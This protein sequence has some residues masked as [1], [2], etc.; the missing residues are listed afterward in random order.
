MADER[1][2]KFEPIC[3]HC[4]EMMDLITTAAKMYGVVGSDHEDEYF[5]TDL[6]QCPATNR[7]VI[8][9]HGQTWFTGDWDTD[10]HEDYVF[11]GK[12]LKD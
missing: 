7:Q 4:C 9:G 5:Q 11:R 1:P 12:K 3:P 8:M 10:Q 6:Y 2:N